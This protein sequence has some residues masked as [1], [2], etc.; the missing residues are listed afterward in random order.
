LGGLL[1]IPVALVPWVRPLF[2]QPPPEH[3]VIERWI[4]REHPGRIHVTRWHPVQANPKGDGVVVRLD[5]R[6]LMPGRGKNVDTS[7]W[8]VIDDNRVTSV[9]SEL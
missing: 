5:Y 7:Q 3:A 8:F 9:D 2:V 6:Y 4:E 1:L